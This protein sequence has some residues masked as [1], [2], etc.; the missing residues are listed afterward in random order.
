[1]V[2]DHMA[3]TRFNHGATV[4][5]DGRVL[6][7]GGAESSTT[8]LA[9]AELIDPVTGKVSPTGSMAGTRVIAVPT[10]LPDG[11]VLVIGLRRYSR[12]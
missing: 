10:L 5:A 1:M 12:L 2:T 4:L 6:V 3:D 7:V 9:T 8:N 11:Q